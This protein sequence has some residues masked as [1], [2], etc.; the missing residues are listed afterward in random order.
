MKDTFK[1][2]KKERKKLSSFLKKKFAKSKQR[3]KNI[4]PERENSEK[5]EKHGKHMEIMTKS[6][7][8]KK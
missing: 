1:K 2:T 5:K 4:H 7:K 8:I 3:D 6:R